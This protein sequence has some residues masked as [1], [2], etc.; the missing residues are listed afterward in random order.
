MAAKKEVL[1]IDYHTN[2]LVREALRRYDTVKEASMYLEVNVR[3]VFRYIRKYNIDY[4]KIK[5]GKQSSKS[6]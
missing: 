2:I 1:N 4:K 6:V 3:T 5:D